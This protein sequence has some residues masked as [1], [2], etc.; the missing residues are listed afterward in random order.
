MNQSEKRCT[1]CRAI[2]LL[3]QYR[4]D[5]RGRDGHKTECRLCE[6]LRTYLWRRTRAGQISERA[7]RKRYNESEHGRAKRAVYRQTEAMRAA[8]GRWIQ[9]PAGQAYQARYRKSAKRKSV[10]ARYAASPKGRAAQRRNCRTEAGRARLARS[11]HKRRSLLENCISTL[12]ADE[13]TTIQLM[14]RGRCH[15]C[16]KVKTLT[17]DH[18]IPM[19]QG[20]HHVKENIVGACRPCNTRKGNK[21]LTLF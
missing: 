14:Q 5:A 6:K 1:K 3:A 8:R 9:S 2:H 4:V 12:T 19:S 17:M 13:W 21:I 11:A 16:R 20:G 15:Y 7:T 18:V 10:A